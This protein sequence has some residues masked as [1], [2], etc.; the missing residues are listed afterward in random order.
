MRTLLCLLIFVV[1]C[2]CVVHCAPNRVTD[3]VIDV[4]PTSVLNLYIF[5]KKRNVAQMEKLFWEISDPKSPKY[6]QY[7]TVNNVRDMFGSSKNS[8][9]TV[10]NWLDQSLSSAFG[11]GVSGNS[12]MNKKLSLTNDI[13]QIQAPVYVLEKVFNTTIVT[14]TNQITGQKFIS[15]SP[16]LQVPASVNEHIEHIGGCYFLLFDDDALQRDRRVKQLESNEILSFVHI[17]PKYTSVSLPAENPLVITVENQWSVSVQIACLNNSIGTMLPNC[18][19]IKEVVIQYGVNGESITQTQVNIP[20][21]SLRV[22]NTSGNT[23]FW[24]GEQTLFLLNYLPYNLSTFL[25]YT[26]GSVS[27]IVYAPV[28]YYASRYTTPNNIASYYGTQNYRANNTRNSQVFAG[29]NGQ[30]FSQSDLNMFFNFF[31]LEKANVSKIIG[32][33]NASNPGLE[34]S[35]DVQY[36]MG[37]GLNVSTQFWSMNA[38]SNDGFMDYMYRISDTSDS[39]IPYVH[40]FS[41]SAH[42]MI[43]I[44]PQLAN[45]LNQEFIKAGLRGLTL[46]FATGDSGVGTRDISKQTYSFCDKFVPTFPAS[47]PYVTAVGATQWS[48]RYT[49]MCEQY[50]SCQ[51]VREIACMS[52]RGGFAT[53]GGG[54]STLFP[55]P[56]YQKNVVNSY[57]NN[58]ASNMPPSTAFNSSGRAY[59]D[60]SIIGS[61]FTVIYQGKSTMISGTSASTPTFAAIVS[62]LNDARLNAGMKPLGFINPWL[63]Q[64][65]ETHPGYFNDIVVGNNNCSDVPQNQDLL[66]YFCCPNGFHAAPGY[67]AVT[68]LGSPKFQKFLSANLAFAMNQSAPKV[69]HFFWITIPLVILIIVALVAVIVGSAY[70]FSKKHHNS[71]LY[72]PLNIESQNPID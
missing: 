22:F 4:N 8:I 28:L 32:Y 30:Y 72:V 38:S 56:N 57:L 34:A 41:Y 69:R 47:S 37:I 61:Q 35:L 70:V 63:Y 14:K 59:P 21:S 13:I 60:I 58:Y 3:N 66:T 25:V 55:M 46:L 39:E 16:S 5:L 7:L 42:E 18:S 54:F 2:F 24:R 50:N 11:S 1:G 45:V 33:N 29:F 17:S 49:P 19:S 9:Q 71:S 44:S 26:N 36:M 51:D 23:T 20:M 43:D 67:D 27:S 10:M 62:L 31:G 48:N 64:L 6:A 12:I 52:D 68:G 53:S 15:A 40:S 65:Y